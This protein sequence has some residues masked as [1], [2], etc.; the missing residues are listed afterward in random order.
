MKREFSVAELNIKKYM[1]AP[2]W[3]EIQDFINE[4]GLSFN[5]FEKFYDLPYNTLTQVKSGARDLPASYWHIIYLRIK[6]AYGSGF[7]YEYS[8][9]ATKNRI[10][11]TLT[12]AL[13]NTSAIDAHTRLTTVK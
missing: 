8:P 4:L 3:A 2:S 12:K 13:T 10:K 1:V 5:R 11:P 7:L 6:P 9:K